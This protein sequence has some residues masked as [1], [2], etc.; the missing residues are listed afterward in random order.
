MTTCWKPKPDLYTHFLKMSR[1][2]PSF[3]GRKYI[4][5]SKKIPTLLMNQKLSFGNHLCCPP[6]SSPDPLINIF[7]LSC[8]VRR[9]AW[10]AWFACLPWQ[11]TIPCHGIGTIP[12]QNSSFREKKKHIVFCLP[13]SKTTNTTDKPLKQKTAVF[14]WGG[15]WWL[16]RLKKTMAKHTSVHPLVQN[17]RFQTEASKESHSLSLRRRPSVV[18]TQQKHHKQKTLRRSSKFKVFLVVQVIFVTSS[19]LGMSWMPLTM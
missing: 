15:A 6:G 7:Q 4:E 5:S 9:F 18:S 10:F 14:F 19:I 8:W 2:L 12:R 13:C 11:R 16:L 3:F 1:S 17:L